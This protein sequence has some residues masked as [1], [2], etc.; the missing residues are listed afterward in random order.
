MEN[1]ELNKEKQRLA[2]FIA[3]EMGDKDASCEQIADLVL[4]L[5]YTRFTAPKALSVEEID[6]IIDQ[7]DDWIEEKPNDTPQRIKYLPC[8]AR[9]II[10]QAIHDA[11]AVGSHEAQ[12]KASPKVIME[13]ILSD[14]CSPIN[15]KIT[16]VVIQPTGYL[17]IPDS[18]PNGFDNEGN[19]IK[20]SYS[21]GSQPTPAEINTRDFWINLFIGDL[22]YLKSLVSIT[23]RTENAVTK[24]DGIEELL[25]KY[26]NTIKKAAPQ[27]SGEEAVEILKDLVNNGWN[28][29]IT[30]RA[31]KFLSTHAHPEPKDSK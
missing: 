28:A 1:E 13:A 24:S 3:I 22:T 31:K 18:L 30:D 6:K 29:G 23:S 2:E 14:N 16:K 4:R 25:T 5:G 12:G 11:Q 9:Q 20:H 19:P 10:A 7:H 21:G 15:L 26:R 8:A 27:S 17:P